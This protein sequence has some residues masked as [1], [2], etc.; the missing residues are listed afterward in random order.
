M[1]F[2]VSAHGIALQ[3]G[4]GNGFVLPSAYW[5]N[6]GTTTRP[7]GISGVV[8]VNHTA[9]RELRYEPPIT[10]SKCPFCGNRQ[11]LEQHGANCVKCGGDVLHEGVL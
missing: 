8:S 5:P 10:W 3:S 2:R 1:D 4:V 11:N 9:S 7:H 6:G